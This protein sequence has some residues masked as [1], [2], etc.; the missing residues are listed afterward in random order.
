[1]Q[2]PPGTTEDGE[3]HPYPMQPLPAWAYIVRVRAS[4]SIIGKKAVLRNRAKRR[5]KAAATKIMPGHAKRGWEYVF[6]PA[7]SALTASF[8]EIVDEVEEC[9]KSSGC[10]KNEMELEEVVRTVYCDRYR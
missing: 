8:D 4:K 9:L 3:E 6:V 5:V 2:A 10:W 1:M 7:R